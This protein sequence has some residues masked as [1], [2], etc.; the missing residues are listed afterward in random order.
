[1][2]WSRVCQ[3]SFGCPDAG[4]PTRAAKS[5]SLQ[6]TMELLS[7]TAPALIRTSAFRTNDRPQRAPR[8]L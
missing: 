7:T 4:A 8:E 3:G 1:M 6:H 5:G 2:A